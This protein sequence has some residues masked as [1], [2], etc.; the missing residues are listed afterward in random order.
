MFKEQLRNDISAVQRDGGFK[1]KSSGGGRYKVN[2]FSQIKWLMWRDGLASYRDQRETKIS[3][4][5]TIAFAVLFGLI[6]LRLKLDQTGVQNI[7]GV[8]F[9]MLVNCTFSNLFPVLNT[10]PA[11]IPIFMREHKN[12]MYRVINF[13][14]SK[15]L[16]DVRIQQL[17]S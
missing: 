16:V 7:N 6:Y 8:L 5:Q 12:G 11:M 2:S 15:F 14:M 3:I 1:E 9:L 13:Y 10:L 17:I 4:V